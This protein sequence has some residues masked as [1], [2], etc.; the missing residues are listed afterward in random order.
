MVLDVVVVHLHQ[1]EV[2]VVIER[3]LA[4]LLG[5]VDLDLFVRP[6][7]PQPAEPDALA[8]RAAVL[9]EHARL[10]GA[11][12]L[13]AR[14]ELL[15][16]VVRERV[17]EA[18]VEA[19]DVDERVLG[20]HLGLDLGRRPD[21]LAL[22]DVL[23]HEVVEAGLGAIGRA[24]RELARVDAHDER[25]VLARHLN[26]VLVLGR[27]VKEE[28][29][30]AS[31]L[32]DAVGD[33]DRVHT[34]A[35][36]ALVRATVLGTRHLELHDGQLVLGASRRR[37]EGVVA[38]LLL[39][40]LLEHLDSLHAHEVGQLARVEV[41]LVG[42]VGERLLAAAHG[43]ELGDADA[44]AVELA[45]GVLGLLVGA[46]ASVRAIGPVVGVLG[47]VVA[48]PQE[49]QR[50]ALEVERRQKR[51]DISVQLLDEVLVLLVGGPVVRVVRHAAD[52]RE[53]AAH[54]LLVDGHLA[55]VARHQDAHLALVDAREQALVDEL[56]VRRLAALEV[57]AREGRLPLARALAS[58]TLDAEDHELLDRVVLDVV[59]VHL[60]ELEV[61]VVAEG[62]GAELRRGVDLDLGVG[63]LVPEPAEPDAL[64]RRAT[65]LLDDTR[66]E[67]ARLLEAGEELLLGVVRERV[68]EA[69]VEASD[70]DER[71]LGAHLSLDL[72]RRPDELALRDVRVHE[73]VEAGLG[74]LGGA[75][76][77]LAGVDAHDERII[78]GRE[79]L[80]LFHVVLVLLRIEE[81]EVARA[82]RLDNR[83]RDRDR[84]NTVAV[85]A[86]VGATVLGARHLE[87]DDGELEHGALGRRQQRVRA[88]PHRGRNQGGA[89][90]HVSR[91]VRRG[92]TSARVTAIQR[93]NTIKV[94]CPKMKPLLARVEY[95]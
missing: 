89:S 17:L 37:T 63:R 6:L 34:V 46:V 84:V 64:A 75:L 80:E 87:L 74:A 93:R 3:G 18:A 42:H 30:R 22:R 60:H 45:H 69:A 88:V 47:D 21:E 31:S 43:L 83:V 19:A 48:R 52:G 53:A 26:K 7:V 91:V 70:V 41:V 13:E 29:A 79:G 86:L 85:G 92:P 38:L 56:A 24:L 72:G 55:R 23:V 33:G 66:L 59:V 20:A 49:R 78:L 95:L 51:R 50:L 11:R 71:V 4:E 58:R 90:A 2:G 94:T 82:A 39:V 5:R 54:R 61:V 77:E 76:R 16:G 8:G 57:L 81:N 32:D 9:L 68:L 67:G 65:V 1:L 36:G 44:R 25:V 73:V 28:V 14:D 35:V 12:L 62:L 27:I 10:E 40:G 15:L